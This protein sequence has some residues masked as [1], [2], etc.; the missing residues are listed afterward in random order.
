MRVIGLAGWSG[1][2]KTTLLAKVIPRL[3]ARGL[4]VSTIK[5]AH[6]G[7]D[8]DQP[9]KDSHTHRTAGA[10][11]VLVSSARRWAQVHELRGEEEPSLYELL[12]R[13]SPVDLVIVEGYKTALHAKLEVYRKDVCKPPLHPNNP[14][15]VGVASDTPFP[16][17]NRPVVS[18][19]DIEA[20]ADVL[21]ER[22]EDIDKVLARAGLRWPGPWP[23]SMPINGF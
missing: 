15:F 23:I 8:V 12:Q 7:F 2:G 4:R 9:G 19:D 5:H 16:D 1:A 20:V 21:V 6:H 3:V 13:L 10:T 11:E 18:I 17:A 22:A 14:Y